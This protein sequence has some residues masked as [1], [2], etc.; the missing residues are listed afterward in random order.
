MPLIDGIQWTIERVE[1][2]GTFA[3][4]TLL[5]DE[6]IIAELKGSTGSSH[7]SFKC[8][9][10]CPYGM[11]AGAS[12]CVVARIKIVRPEEGGKRHNLTGSH[13]KKF[14]LNHASP[15]ENKNS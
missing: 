15:A 9:D 12:N 10:D 14:W 2:P 11:P 5:S 4:N 8:P 3:R 7:Q 1:R 13:V 6:A